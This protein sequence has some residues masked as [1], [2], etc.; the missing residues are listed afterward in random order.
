MPLP[1]RAGRLTPVTLHEFDLLRAHRAL[2]LAG[3]TGRGGGVS[4][5]PY[6]SLNLGLHVGD[7]PRAVVENRHRV[8]QALGV[9]LSAFAVGRQVHG[10]EV[11]VVIAADR[12]GGAL[13][14]DDAFPDTDAL[15]TRE[16]G[17]VLA[18]LLADC[19]PVILFD[20]LTP[21]IGVA[22]A[23]WKG[24]LAHIV[25]NAV[26]GMQ[27]EFGSD[28]LS[29]LAAIGPSIGP[30]SYEVSAD[31]AERLRAEFPD[32]G[33]VRPHGSGHTPGNDSGHTP[34]N[35]SGH[36]PGNDSGHTPGNDSGHTPGND[37]GHTP[38]NDSG[39][40]PGND[41]GHT[42]GNDSGHTSGNDKHLL[43]LW[44][45]N[46]ADLLAAGVPRERI[47]VAGLDTFQ[48]S[49]QFFSHRRQQ[50]TGRFMALAMLRE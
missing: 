12:G 39:H 42:P 41:S 49:G 29:L 4:E 24:T 38:G 22:H 16:R 43:D 27:R 2:L 7:D 26:V 28:P 35:D 44:G 8:A 20:P 30:A 13:T 25:R 46:T 47:E 3:C 10:G 9:E 18:V 50:P 40:T 21:A 45:A 6:A 31:V 1:G 15:I 33:I 23:G 37:S 36:T 17:I 32:E 14:A 11:R 19:V 34:G 5:A 48:R